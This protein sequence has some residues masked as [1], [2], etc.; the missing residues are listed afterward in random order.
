MTALDANGPNAAQ[1]AFW[2]ETG[3]PGW[4]AMQ[5]EL[6]RELSEL[7]LVA[8]SAMAPRAGERIIDVGCGCGATTLEL[9]RRV[10]PEGGVL[11]VDI[12]A[13]MLAVARERA[14]AAG[15]T[16]ARF[17][18]ADA[19]VYAFEPAHGAF[20]RFGV[21]FFED[22]VAAFENIRRGF[23]PRGRLAFVCWRP[24][25]LNPW[26]TV[27]MNAVAPLLPSPPPAPIPG[28]PGPFAFADRDRLFGILRDA[29]FGAISIDPH[30]AKVAWG[31]L[32]TSV[33]MALRLGPVAALA[34]ENPPL[35]EAMTD[36]IRAAVAPHLGA[37]GVQLDSA[38][39]I[40]LAK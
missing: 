2:N 35:Q 13:P 31:D 12:S 39:W 6:D 3:G 17:I 5:D 30:D 11:G 14:A 9:A 38:S 15:L 19:Q 25:V 21:M 20:S 34:R 24:L 33:R 8:M 40:V 28:A 27:P 32:E 26:M 7:G 1:I 22:P 29:G 10:G 36:A 4:V 37:D 23:K 16:Q 18:Q